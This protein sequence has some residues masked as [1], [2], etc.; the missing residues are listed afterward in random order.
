MIPNDISFFLGWIALSSDVLIA[1]SYVCILAALIH[2]IR[3]R[4]DSAYFGF[5]GILGVFI[6]LEGALHLLRLRDFYTQEFY[7]SEVIV[8]AIAAMI[9]LIFSAILLKF[10]PKAV[11]FPTPSELKAAIAKL[12][13][14]IRM[15]QEAEQEWRRANEQ[16]LSETEKHFRALI[17]NAHDITTVLDRDG[18]I[19]YESPS[20][21][22]ILG[23]SRG[24]LMGQCVFDLVHPHDLRKVK[25]AFKHGVSSPKENR[26]I[27]LRIKHRD[28]S[29][30]FI[31]AIGRNL[32]E[33]PVVKGLIVNA[34]D[35]TERKQAENKIR[36]LPSLIQAVGE[37]NDFHSALE[38]ALQKLCET[39]GWDYGEAWIPRSDGKVLQCSP[40]WYGHNGL[41]KFRQATLELRFPMGM[42]L[43]GTVWA[44][45]APLWV[46]NVGD[47]SNKVF[48][49]ARLAK[50]AGVKTALGVPVLSEGEVLAILVFCMYESCPE[51]KRLIDLISS[52]ATQLGAFFHRKRAEQELK[53]A[54]EQLE[55]RV[56]ARTEELGRANEALQKEILERKQTEE[57]LRKSRQNYQTLVNSIEGIVW[58]FDLAASKFTFVSQ[59]SNRI[60]GYPI[61]VWFSEPTFWQDHIHGK[62]RESALQFRSDIIREKKGGHSEYRMISADGRMIWVRDM[63]TI[64][65]EEDQPVKLRGVMVDITE[66]RQVEAALSQ[67]RNFA[68]AVLDTAGAVVMIL[69]PE[70]R[71]V[72]WNRAGTQI[73]GYSV[74][75]VK[76]KYIW[77]LF[78][79]PDEI[80]KIKTIF[81]RLL[82]GQFPANYES[83]W[84]AK[85]G[86]SRVIA[87]SSTVLLGKDDSVAHI[88]ATGIDVTKR[89]EA[90][91]KLK[92]AITNLAFS[93][94]ELDKSSRHLREANER[95]KR[96]DEIKSHFISAA[97]HELRTPLTSLK[98]YV[99]IILQEEVGT[100]N[101]KQREFLC[102]VKESTDRLHRLL[103]ELLDISKIESGQVKMKLQMTN[104]RDLLK[105]ELMIFKPQ[106]D[107]KSISLS[108]ETDQQLNAVSC[109]PDKIREVMDNLISN[110]I[111]YTP[112]NGKIKI[113]AKNQENDVRIDVR[114]TGIGIRK[115]DQVRIFEP[116]QHIE[117]NGAE[118][119][120]ES[121]GLGLALVKEIVN[122]HGGS[123]HV[124]SDE[125]NGSCFSVVLRNAEEIQAL[126]PIDWMATH[127]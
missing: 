88:I 21:E 35:I 121:T 99:E 24:T 12:N 5:L 122:A 124:A 57:S 8:K 47:A 22:R 19:R 85:D 44:A 78:L 79:T 50:E 105:D 27:E 62:D 6:F 80:P 96:I 36:L 76:G 115:E 13:F 7:W 33:D 30:R 120:E 107:E 15:H 73:S 32:L 101:E 70:G 53:G 56:R 103:N 23:Y 81:S 25:I 84:V 69:D 31:E 38:V 90:E 45:K 116:F 82:A 71:M 1:I 48:T 52:V 65:L 77:D 11:T 61:D 74:S 111:K 40:A 4:K 125:G 113:Y 37:T 29:W 42:G 66:R 114:D 126:D 100:I 75:E 60:L 51:D 39:T 10:T 112:R 34:R 20:M 68:Q 67:E 87:W 110:A 63:V 58:E 54:H 117:K 118:R 55:D 102:Y 72:R 17:E 18:I 95:L 98:G 92:E 97:S 123:V 59:Q 3:S 64:V 89:E 2:F 41:E 127:E 94:E 83:N 108:L 109:D 49:R 104:L 91:Q 119:S 16:A 43:V 86:S 46:R 93:N 14:Q 9:S 28:G 106:A 26:F